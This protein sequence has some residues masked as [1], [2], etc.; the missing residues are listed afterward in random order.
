MGI[1]V[2]FSDDIHSARGAAIL[3]FSHRLPPS[4]PAPMKTD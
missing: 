1:G 3:P 4:R 2:A